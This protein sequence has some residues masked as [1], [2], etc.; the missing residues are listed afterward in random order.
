[1][2][3]H[4]VKTK[5][6]FPKEERIPVCFHLGSLKAP[7]DSLSLFVLISLACIS[8]ITRS[9]MT[10]DREWFWVIVEEWMQRSIVNGM[11]STISHHGTKSTISLQH[12]CVSSVP[13]CVL[14]RY[15]GLHYILVST[16][17]IWVSF[18]RENMVKFR[19]TPL[20]TSTWI[21][22]ANGS[23]R[24]VSG[25]TGTLVSYCRW[26]S[27]VCV[28]V[29]AWPFTQTPSSTRVGTFKFNLPV[30]ADS[31]TLQVQYIKTLCVN[32]QRRCA[33]KVRDKTL[34][35]YTLTVSLSPPSLF[36]GLFMV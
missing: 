2:K 15:T 28:C 27:Y 34:S 7:P 5:D 35:M 14:L 22:S 4:Q 8:G 1:M 30:N 9:S 19:K 24:L 11:E 20:N 25:R 18:H 13:M 36:L 33:T 3:S 12:P 23:W 10:A 26:Q 17:N 32:P 6:S 16:A 31:F 21:E 29:C